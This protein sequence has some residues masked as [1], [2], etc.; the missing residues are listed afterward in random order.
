MAEGAI[1]LKIYTCSIYIY[2]HSPETY[3]Q[4]IYR[5][6]SACMKLRIP[7]FFNIYCYF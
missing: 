6:Y 2:L 4:H 1:K 7:Q 5:I 3:I